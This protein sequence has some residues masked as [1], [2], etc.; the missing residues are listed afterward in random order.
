M[1]CANPFREHAGWPQT[2]SAA[3]IAATGAGEPRSSLNPPYGVT[4]ARLPNW[5]RL[6]P[7]PS[8]P[9]STVSYPIASRNLVTAAFAYGS[10]PAIGRALQSGAPAGRASQRR[11]MPGGDVVERFHHERGAQVPLEDF[12]AE[13][14]AVV[15]LRYPPVAPRH[16]V[17]RVEDWFAGQRR[18]R[19]C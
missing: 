5:K 16:V 7:D 19:Y 13:H 9:A 12:A 18:R 14:G 15:E 8:V 17:D 6:P 4:N 2:P 10:S 1:S 3:R 11:Q